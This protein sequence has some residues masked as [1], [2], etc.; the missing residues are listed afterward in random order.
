[1]SAERKKILIIKLGALGD[2][3]IATAHIRMLLD[4]H[5]QDKVSLITS[6]SYAGLFEEQGFNEILVMPRGNAGALLKMM[7]K[8]FVQGFDVVYDMQS[9]D[10]SALLVLASRA[11]KRIGFGHRFIYSDHEKPGNRQRHIHLRSKELFAGLGLPEASDMPVIPA[12]AEVVARVAAWKKQSS[13]GR[14]VLMHA[15]SSPKWLS[16][17]WAP[18][19][20]IELAELLATEGIQ[21]VWVGAN[22]EI[23]LNALLAEKVGIAA[24]NLFSFRELVEVGRGAEFAVVSD[25]GP[26]HLISASGIPVYA[27]FGP[28]DSNRSHAIGQL[29]N[30]LS[31]NADCSPCFLPVCPAD[32]GHKCLNDISVSDVYNRLKA[33]ECI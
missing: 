23:Q 18:E 32:K 21:V 25:S 9:N 8:V 5:K 4:Y 14:Y 27:F 7:G 17:R 11:G 24:T 19:R 3:V 33:D 1:M 16:K 28:T 15:G 13:L 29:N 20:Y 22:D 31:S 30:V 26:M 10:R 12:S 6:P 2:V